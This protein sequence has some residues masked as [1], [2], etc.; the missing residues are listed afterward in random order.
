M[1]TAYLICHWAETFETS[2]SRKIVGP[3]KWVGIP[4]KHDGT[5]Y[6]SVILA[7]NGPLIL[8]A[9]W[10]MVQVA[11]KMPVRGLLANENGPFDAERLAIKTG[12]PQKI[13]GFALNLLTN[14]RINWLQQVE[15]D[16]N[17]PFAENCEHLGVNQRLSARVSGHQRAP[18]GNGEP[19]SHEGNAANPPTSAGCSG[20]NGRHQRMPADASGDQSVL[21]DRTLQEKTGEEKTLS[22]AS[23]RASR[24]GAEL[25]TDYET[26]QQVISEHVFRETDPGRW[27]HQAMEGLSHHLPIRR[28]DVKL[29]S[30]FHRIPP[31][32]SVQELK[33]RRQSP[34]TLMPNWSDEVIRARRFREK[35]GAGMSDP[36][37]AK[38]EPAR[39]KEFFRWKYGED[40]RLPE[41]F[42]QLGGDQLR[43]WETEHEKFEAEAAK[44]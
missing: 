12:L 2:E 24:P 10:A 44:K 21:Q 6:R 16:E 27:S 35:I 33:T 28:K 8:C 23:E 30:W 39:W 40:I 18:A 5:G 14:H 31:D 9:W 41:R 37:R 1:A 15:W 11:A 42:D 3:L 17:L 19:L 7:K 32:D 22:S 20:V 4:T 25:I 34:G 36:D 43:E 29:V 38:K 26:A 13:F